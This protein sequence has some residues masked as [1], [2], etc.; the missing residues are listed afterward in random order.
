MAKR[1]KLAGAALAAYRRK[2]SRS[3]ALVRRGST[4]VRT[5]TR[6]VK[7][8]RR[9]GR[10]GGS[11]GGGARTLRGQVRDFI[12]AMAYGFATGDHGKAPAVRAFV[13]KVPVLAQIGAPA[14]HGLILHFIAGQ[15][16]GKLR[17]AAG[18]LSHAALMHAAHNLGGSGFELDKFQTM[19]GDEDYL[20]GDIDDDLGDDE[21]GDDDAE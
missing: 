20:S 5:R 11:A 4:A 8:G 10:R 9:R 17:M 18:H 21:V 6:Y 12:G 19:A 2:R 15:T 1:R 7:I 13:R 14:T 16:S 3:T